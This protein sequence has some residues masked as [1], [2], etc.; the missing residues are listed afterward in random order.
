MAANVPL[1]PATILDQDD[2]E[3]N[4]DDHVIERRLTKLRLAGPELSH[5][6]QN[7]V[8]AVQ[9]LAD[10]DPY[11]TFGINAVIEFITAHKPTPEA[12]LDMV[13]SITKCSKDISQ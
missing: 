2:D 6:R 12:L 5:S 11:V 8:E 7:N 3:M 10:L 13:A 1:H 4:I 9:R